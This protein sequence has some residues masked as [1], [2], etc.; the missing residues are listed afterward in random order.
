MVCVGVL[1]TWVLCTAFLVHVGVFREDATNN[2]TKLKG[3]EVA[4]VSSHRR[5]NRRR[6]SINTNNNNKRIK[7]DK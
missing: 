7:G 3:V 5:G 2:L 6:R 4:C 1:I